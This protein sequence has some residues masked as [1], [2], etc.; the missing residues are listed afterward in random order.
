MSE[1]Y[2]E[3]KAVLD[4]VKSSAWSYFKCRVSGEEIDKSFVHCKLCLDK[5]KKRRSSTA[6]AQRISPI[7][8]KLGTRQITSLQKRRRRQESILDHF[9]GGQSKAVPK[10]LKS[11]ERWKELALAIAKW[12]CKSSRSTKNDKND[13]VPTFHCLSP[14]CSPRI[15][16]PQQNDTGQIH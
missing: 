1:S 3:A 10:W 2:R 11:S 16:S 12:F 5:R 4:N 6:A 15:R 13:R 8:S 14:A 9:G 7:I